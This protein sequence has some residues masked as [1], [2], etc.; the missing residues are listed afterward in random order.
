M[1]LDDIEIVFNI[2]IFGSMLFDIDNNKLGS[3]P[4]NHGDFIFK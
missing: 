4:N 2:K 1:K 3:K